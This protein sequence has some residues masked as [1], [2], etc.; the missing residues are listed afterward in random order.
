M[1]IVVNLFDIIGLCILL[2]G[3]PLICLIGF[4]GYEISCLIAWIQERIWKK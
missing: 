3:I 1:K 4:I 2:F